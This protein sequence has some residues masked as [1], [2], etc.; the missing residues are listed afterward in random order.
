MDLKYYTTTRAVQSDHANSRWLA[1]LRLADG[2]DRDVP[3][4]RVE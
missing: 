4:I 2:H 1:K 3:Q